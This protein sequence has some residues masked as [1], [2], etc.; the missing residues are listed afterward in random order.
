MSHA[1]DGTTVDQ[2][3]LSEMLY[4]VQHL[5]QDENNAHDLDT[6]Q[7]VKSNATLSDADIE[8]LNGPSYELV[9][10]RARQDVGWRSSIAPVRKLFNVEIL[11]V[12]TR[13]AEDPENDYEVIDV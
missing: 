6:L 1:F 11:W 4:A 12:S 13:V 7:R 3:E 9:A 8:S 2:V 10:E 5:L